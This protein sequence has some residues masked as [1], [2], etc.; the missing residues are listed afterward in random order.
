MIRVVLACLAFACGALAP[1]AD[2]VLAQSSRA[3]P[4]RTYGNARFGTIAEV[5]RDWRAG[6]EPEN[7]D[8]LDFTSPDA[9][10]TI[11]VS[12][13]LNIDGTIEHAMASRGQPM[14]GETITCQLRRSPRLRWSLQ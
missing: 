7:G 12:G 4:W 6:H 9:E 8:G 3:Q 14:E 1:T 10:A 5:P 2:P 11:T 13:G